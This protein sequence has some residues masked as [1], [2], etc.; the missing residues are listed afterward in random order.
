M[1]MNAH[2]PR[3]YSSTRG[4]AIS[5]E[6]RDGESSTTISVWCARI[7]ALHF[8]G[9]LDDAIAL[10]AARDLTEGAIEPERL[11]I[12]LAQGTL[13]ADRVFHA[14]RGYDEAAAILDTAR[15]LAERLHD[16]RSAATA[17]DLLG[18][19]D[20]YRVMQAGSDDYAPALQRFQTALARR[21]ELDDSR[22][23]AESLFHVGLIHERWEQYDDALDF[24]RR[25]YTLARDYG[26]LLEQSYA[27]RHLGGGEQEVGDLDAALVYFRESLAL[28]QEVGY[29][30]LLPL[31]HIAL[32]EVMLARNEGDGAAHE[33]EQAHALAQSMQSPLVMVFA[34]LALSELAHAR[35]DEDARREYAEQALS[36][37]QEDRLPLG[38]RAAQAALAATAQEHI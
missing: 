8:A 5:V 23:V 21:E 20:Y 33:Y 10:F 36:R 34:L 32:G 15:A 31:A 7:E 26:H 6:M 22:G 1:R 19:A 28:R 11:R 29:T 35:G 3:R 24:Y 4:G 12:S 27:A 25:A 37:A 16:E 13:F 9:R 38:G 30:L 17:L 18:M 2:R 14:D